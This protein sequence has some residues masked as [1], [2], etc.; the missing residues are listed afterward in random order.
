MNIVLCL[1]AAICSCKCFLAHSLALPY[2]T[3]GLKTARKRNYENDAG[4]V[5][6]QQLEVFQSQFY[7]SVDKNQDGKASF[8]EV[9]DY[10]SKY[11]PVIKD[12]EI[13]K[14]INRRDINGNGIIDFIPDYISEVVSPSYGL[15]KAKEW[16][17]LE[18]SNRDGFVSRS[19]L[20]Q[21]AI[22]VGL[23]PRD[24]RDTVDMFYMTGD[25]NGDG[26]LNWEEYSSVVM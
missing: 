26:K 12:S 8:E 11:N 22:N 10:L 1:F 25:K 18:D 2:S 17:Q 20:I 15:S 16:F 23:S 14:F 6:I 4:C 9:K 19:E 3:H 5:S 7:N 24:A 21:I 13:G